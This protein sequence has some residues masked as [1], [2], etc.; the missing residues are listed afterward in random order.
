MENIP[1]KFIYI[2]SVSYNS[3]FSQLL[4]FKNSNKLLASWM[5]ICRIS[6]IFIFLAFYFNLLFFH[7]F[8]ATFYLSYRNANVS[9]FGEKK[10]L[11]FCL[12]PSLQ[13]FF[14]LLLSKTKL[15]AIIYFAVKAI[16]LALLH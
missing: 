7:Y 11:I 8:Y 9:D 4:H 12:I 5:K 6:M 16:Q 13:P 1:Q 3:R 15:P 14:L 10:N 2:L